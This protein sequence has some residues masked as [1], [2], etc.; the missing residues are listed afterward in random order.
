MN[1]SNESFDE[2]S[3]KIGLI[4]CTPELTTKVKFL[5]ELAEIKNGDLLKKILQYTYDT[6]TYTYGI[7]DTS[8]MNF[9]KDLQIFPKYSNLFELLDD[10]NTRKITGDVARAS[11]RKFFD[12]NHDNT[13]GLFLIR[14]LSRDLKMYLGLKSI[15]KVYP[16]IIQKTK[17]C[18]CSVLN[19]KNAR[20]I[21]YPCYV[22]LKCDG[23]YREAHVK[24]G[25]VTFRTRSGEPYDNPIMAKIM[26]DYPNGYYLGEFTVGKADEPDENRA[27]CNGMINS[28]NPCFVNI[29]FTMWDYLS[30][31]EYTGK[32][33]TPYYER[34]KDLTKIVQEHEPYTE[35]IHVVQNYEAHNL[36]EILQI[37]STF[38]KHGLEGSVVKDKDMIFKDGTSNQ[39]WKVKLKV[40]ADVRI[41]AF[42]KGTIGTKYENQNKVLI[43]ET[44]DGKIKGKTSGLTDKEVKDVTANP[45]KYLGKIISV[46]FN[47]LSKAE[48]HEYYALS[49]PRFIEFRFDKESTDTLE[50]VQELC[51]MSRNLKN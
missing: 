46:Q 30:D 1:Y 15:L 42:E 48:G 22:Q 36:D 7:S 38:M 29:H 11:A 25:E 12:D 37:T 17:Y 49:H 44:D 41:T 26:K 50:R 33:K 2:I 23:T 45:D 9:T 24:D 51:D 5:R 4:A 40:D 47:D 8:V 35:L 21:K 31:E 43:F 10:L 14:I 32:V 39:Q 13:R 3:A 28:N 19:E 20:K 27:K 16:D 34:F 18:R 6:V